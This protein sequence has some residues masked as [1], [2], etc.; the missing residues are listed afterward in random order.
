MN[1]I[2]EVPIIVKLRQQLIKWITYVVF[3]LSFAFFVVGIFNPGNYSFGALLQ[4]IFISM[5]LILNLLKKYSLA[6]SFFVIFSTIVLI[7]QSYI[8]NSAMVFCSI[9]LV[10]ILSSLLKDFWF[11]TISF[12]ISILSLVIFIFLGVFTISQTLAPSSNV[13]L[14]NNI[15][16]A[17]PVILVSYIYSFINTRFIIHSIA[18]LHEKNK[19]I[20]ETQELLISQAR[21]ES[22]Q[23]MAGGFAHDFNNL[24]TGIMGNLSLAISDKNL[25]ET[26]H[27]CLEDAQQASIQMRNLVLQLLTFSKNHKISISK[28]NDFRKL[29]KNTIK[30]SLTGRKSK[31]IVKIEP[32][33]LEF[34]G[35]PV[36]IGQ[37]IQ[38]FLINADQSMDSGGTVEIIAE[39]HRLTE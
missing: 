26:T 8:Q 1:S 28:N 10:L 33:L 7:L 29:L 38:N 11:T 21:T 15:Q 27:A 6:S 18:K 17:F 14:A 30:I 3:V 39:N 12:I 16:I 2:E 34:D 5:T 22:I 32:D 13:P 20:Q 35:D 4:F 23:L 19:K 37:V 9:G 31:E 24:L 36:Q 25:S